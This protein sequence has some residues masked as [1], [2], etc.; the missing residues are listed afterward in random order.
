VAEPEPTPRREQLIATAADAGVRLDVFVTRQLSALSRS[1]VRRMIDAGLVTVAGRR[2]KASLALDVGAEIV[3]TVPAVAPA[4]PAAEPLPLSVVYEDADIVVVDK[5]AG[6]VVHPAAGHASGTLVN[7]L[8]YHVRGLSGVGG[9]A[10]PGIVHRLDRGTSGLIVVAKHDAAHRALV[11]QFHDR[12]VTK[13]YL[14]LVWGRVETGLE[15][16]ASIGRDPHDR[17]K[18]SGRSARG[19]T[20][21]TSVVLAERLGEVTFVRISIATGRTHQIR[22]HLSEAG[23]AVVGDALYGGDRK[24]LPPGLAALARLGRPFLHAAALA[25]VHPVSGVPVTF[26]AP[27]PADLADVLAAIR[28]ARAAHVPEDTP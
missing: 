21:R 13:E 1:Q 25:F 20:A 24:R 26:E 17:K 12:G 28:R 16:T 10:R 9:Q 27:L 18:M 8:L 14:A 15:L 19:R 5:P 3:V 6:M 11:A 23:H 4:A 7:A 22:V 2:A